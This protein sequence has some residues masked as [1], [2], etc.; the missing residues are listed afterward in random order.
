MPPIV[1]NLFL[2]KKFVVALLTGGGAVAMYFGYNVDPTK[3]LA[4]LSPFLLYIGAQ[5]W[6]DSGKE[7]A[8]VNQ[9]TALQTQQMTQDHEVKLQQMVQDH[10]VKL[11]SLRPP[12]LNVSTTLDSSTAAGNPQ[13]GV[14]ILGCMVALAAGGMLAI[15]LWACT[16][17]QLKNDVVAA[18]TAVINCTAQQ[19]GAT[20]GLDLATLS[21]VVNLA[22]AERTKC[23]PIGGSLSWTCVKGDLLAMGKTLG[24][25]AF[26][27]LVTEAAGVLT[28]P[29]SNLSAATPIL[30]GRDEFASFRAQVEPGVTIMYHG[31]ASDF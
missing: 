17:E 8:L 2:S 12:A 14:S 22:A 7:Q 15:M 16:K 3:I 20:P 6:A 1:K 10:E 27:A 26:L 21:A 5:G 25:C 9:A 30:P 29:G 31:A 24:G 18:K 19:L 28:T 13:A 4:I 23:T 11:E